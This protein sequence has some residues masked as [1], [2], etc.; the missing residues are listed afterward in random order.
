MKRPGSPQ[1]QVFWYLKQG[2]ATS[3]VQDLTV[4]VVIVGGGMAGLHAA[5]AFSERGKKVALLEQYL[6]GSG[7]TGKSSGF[8]TPN[9]ELSFTDFI[10]RY[11]FATAHQIWSLFVRGSDDIRATIT[12]NNLRCGYVPQNT[13]IVANSVRDLRALAK[14]HEN[15]VKGNFPSVFYT[16]SEL[17]QHINSAGYVGGVGYQDT[18]GIDPYQYCQELK[19]I[20]QERGVLIFEE[21]PVLSLQDHA[22]MTPHARVQ[23]EHIIVCTDRFLPELGILSPDV[24][25]AQTFVMAS[26][27]LTPEQ[28][29][30]IFPRDQLLV[31][32]TE[33]IYNYFRITADNRLLLGGGSLLTTYASYA[34]HESSYMFSKLTN[35]FAKKFPQ[36]AT[37]QFQEMWPGLIGLS[38]DIVPLAGRDAKRP[39]LYYVGAAAGLPIAAGLGRY[40]AEHIIDGRTDLDHCFSP[41]RSY[42]ISGLLQKL[43]GKRLSFA[44]SN[45]IAT[46]L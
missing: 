21:T 26:E 38:K 4:D 12:D 14:E 25:Q 24:Y 22:V 15:L 28:I 44:F 39:Y 6:C 30:A 5:K 31:W 8:V 42:Y 43:L 41:Y 35:Y 18:Y 2:A 29:A 13:L 34:R 17:L 11:G 46:Q 33:M 3:R 9:A 16:G 7:A 36:L 45:F 37:L 23:A 19:R 32:D 10:R 1:D 27:Q 40:S 20:L